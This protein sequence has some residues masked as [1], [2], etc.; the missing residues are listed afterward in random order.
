MSSE[1]WIDCPTD[2]MTVSPPFC[3]RGGFL[4]DEGSLTITCEIFCPGHDPTVLQQQVNIAQKRPMAA[5]I[6]PFCFKITAAANCVVSITVSASAPG[7]G[8]GPSPIPVEES[9]STVV[10]VTI[11]GTGGS[12]CQCPD[13]C[14][15]PGPGPTPT[16]NP[17]TV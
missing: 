11:T 17:T 16:P 1:I 8:G 5:G 2:G 4:T 3:I 7:P 14:Y 9:S 6:T 10:D 12:D 13:D 15:S